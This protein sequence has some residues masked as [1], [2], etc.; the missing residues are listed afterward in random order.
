MG[1]VERLPHVHKVDATRGQTHFIVKTASHVGD[2]KGAVQGLKFALN[3]TEIETSYF[4]VR[5][6]FCNFNGPYSY[7]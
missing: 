4:T 2:M 6:L 5:E 1:A 7:H 3:W